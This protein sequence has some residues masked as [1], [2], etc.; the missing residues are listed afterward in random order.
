M[1]SVRAAI[2]AA[3]TEADGSEERAERLRTEL[4]VTLGALEESLR[5]PITALKA[6]IEALWAPTEAAA[7]AAAA[8]VHATAS[9]HTDLT[10]GLEALQASVGRSVEQLVEATRAEAAARQAGFAAVQRQIEDLVSATRS[11]AEAQAELREV[12]AQLWGGEPPT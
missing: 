10:R 5:S 7:S 4:V 3:Q 8:Q 11:I 6:P 2:A 9:L 1:A 12:V